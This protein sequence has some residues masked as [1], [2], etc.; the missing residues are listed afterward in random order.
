[1]NWVK[2]IRAILGRFWY[3]VFKEVDFILGIEYLE[4]IY[5][6]LIERGQQNWFSGL[7]AKYLGVQQD[8]MP[9]VVY[10]EYPIQ[11]RYYTIDEA[12]QDD[13]GASMSSV[14][15][16]AEWAGVVVNTI[17]I[18]YTLQDHVFKY[19]KTLINGLDF[20]YSNGALLFYTNPETFGWTIVRRTT[21][22]GE[23]HKYYRIFGTRK[24]VKRAAEMVYGF[25]S[26]ELVD[27]AETVWAMHQ[28]GASWLLTKKLIGAYTDTTISETAGTVVDIWTENNQNCVLVGDTVYHS[29]SPVA[30]S[31][32]AQVNVGDVLFG[33]SRFYP[34]SNLI[35]L[36]GGTLSNL[37]EQLPAISVRTDVGVLTAK[38]EDMEAMVTSGGAYVLPLVDVTGGTMATEYLNR[39]EELENDVDC[40]H[41][42]AAIESTVNPFEFVLQKLRRG[43]DGVVTI[44]GSY[45]KT[46][47][48]ALSCIY[49]HMNTG[50]V[51]GVYVN[52]GTADSAVAVDGD[53]EATVTAVADDGN[54]DITTDGSEA[55]A[56][57]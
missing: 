48:P 1:M 19:T 42:N 15:T 14:N 12:I 13:T 16:T 44:T 51:L 46:L 3:T 37:A 39:C 24:Q 32:G 52:T 56:T 34:S 18:P 26:P 41:L 25:I 9:F 17:P 21:K 28:L 55:V 23:L 38:N 45:L 4:A 7:I 40:P 22:D 10:I 36:A 31:I 50:G 20:T 8:A 47:E 57:I 54:L 29:Q 30:V 35:T 11:K 27:Q 33:S 49:K 6:K 53:S 2:I 5:A 43:R